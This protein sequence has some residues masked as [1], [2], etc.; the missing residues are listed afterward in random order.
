[1]N[2]ALK[3]RTIY[4]PYMCD[5]VYPMGAAL[6]AFGLTVEFLPRPDEETLAIG[7]DLCRGRECLPCFISTG[8]IIRRARR[9][10][11]EPARAA[12]LMPTTEG[13]CRFGQYLTFQRE[14]LHQ[15]GLSEV[16]FLSPN[17][18]NAYRDFGEKATAIRKLV[19]QGIVAVDLLQKLLHAY[20]PYEVEPGATAAVYEAALQRVSVAVGAGGGRRVVAAMA[21]AAAAFS[22]LARHEPG[23]RPR[24]GLVGEVYLRLNTFSNQEVVR[25]VE[26]AG[27]EVVMASL[28]EWL[29]YMNWCS[30]TLT[31]ATGRY[32]V[33]FL[34]YLTDRY[35]A[36]MERRIAAPVAHLLRHP[37]ESPIAHVL[38]L[39]APDLDPTLGN[40]AVLSL[41]KAAEL[42]QIDGLD[43]VL[44][45]MPF[46]CMPGIVVAGLAPRLRSRLNGIPWL[47]VSYDAQ[48]GT[49]LNTRLEA[50]MYQ[51]R[52]FR[53]VA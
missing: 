16:I 5:H 39:I 4:I 22:G 33:S 12:I 1:M 51:A 13:S 26:A 25:Q 36:R 50:F 37:V 41:G 35:Q 49:N 47:D 2:A 7:L 11:F 23:R 27:G 10:D 46:S 17:S 48:G 20:R 21:G 45:V 8:D 53:A 24:I 38:D 44:N 32:G 43:G 40:E 42:A 29:Y 18:H 19:W 15:R 34:I 3:E 52:Q 31:R 14:L 30:G 6:T 28:M 9:P